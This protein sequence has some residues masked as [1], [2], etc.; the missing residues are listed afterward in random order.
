MKKTILSLAILAMSALLC[1]AQESVSSNPDYKYVAPISVE[2]MQFNTQAM[3]DSA[4]STDAYIAE[5]NALL[6]QLNAEKNAIEGLTKGL[7][8]ERNLYSGELAT[9]KNRKK[10]LAQ[11][12]KNL[13]ADIKSYDSYLKDVKKHYD[14]IKKMDDASCEAIRDHSRRLSGLEDRYEDEKKRTEALLDRINKNA[15]QEVNDS[16]S[17]LNDF[18]LEL[19]DKETRLKNLAAQNKTNIE[20]V[21]G[22][23]KTA[24]GK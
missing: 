13:L 17:V 4:I 22:A 12:Q 19:T 16:F 3:R 18:L 6:K 9:Y 24:N 15:E 7:K 14:I 10:Q 21:K 11:M 20:I 23:L 8:L 2:C 5:L 1:N